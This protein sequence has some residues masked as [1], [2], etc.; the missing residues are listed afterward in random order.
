[1]TGILPRLWGTKH[2]GI[3]R[4]PD[5][6]RAIL[7]ADFN[8][9]EQAGIVS[10]RETPHALE[11][12]GH[13]MLFAALVFMILVNPFLTETTGFQSVAG[14]LMMAVM[15]TAV[16]TVA[17]DPRHFYITIGLGAL[18]AVGQLA[19]LFQYS[20]SLNVMRYLFTTLFLIYVC[21]LL[22]SDIILRSHTVTR[23]LLF[24]S[25]NIYLMAGLAF[26][27]LYGLIEYLQPGSFT[28]VREFTNRED[29]ALPFIYFSFV[30]MT[31]LGYGDVVPLTRFG[32]T[33]AYVQAVFG[34][35]YLAILVARLVGLHIVG[36]RHH[37]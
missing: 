17:R 26:A 36:K 11:L 12:Q 10:G 28:G 3:S 34:Q 6:S 30:T 33:A 1:V 15:V 9:Q 20:E 37:D 18:A 35:L 23:E 25:V 22:L 4:P 19:L 29:A 32:A 7:Q 5:R 16:R 24:G 8:R 13:R 31:T 21:A 2:P 27:F 14:V